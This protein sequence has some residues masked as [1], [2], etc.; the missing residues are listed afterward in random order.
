MLS[1]NLI[2]HSD[3]KTILELGDDKI[4]QDLIGKFIDYGG[5]YK[6]FEYG[7]TQVIKIPTSKEEIFYRIANWGHE[8]LDY[9]SKYRQLVM[10]RDTSLDLVFQSKLPLSYLAQTV[11][12][13]KIIIQDKVRT[14]SQ[15]FDRL[16][17]SRQKQCLDSL[18]NFYE[19]LWQ[20]GIHETVHCYTLNCGFDASENIVLFDFGELTCDL[21]KVK[22][23]I[24][25]S[26]ILHSYSTRCLGE[27]TLSYMTKIVGGIW[28]TNNLEKLW[29]SK[30]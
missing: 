1:D 2:S 19:V 27:D 13:N 12:H 24:E 10:D 8:T 21:I 18:L 17:I 20:Y 9:E 15:V 26:Q 25:K 22:E 3:P 29:L 16:D 14:W 11:K 30:K 4:K 6:V 23:D 7:E 5:Q 28:T